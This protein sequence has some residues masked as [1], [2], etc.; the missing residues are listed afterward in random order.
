MWDSQLFNDKIF[1]NP[2]KKRRYFLIPY[3]FH[4]THHGDYFIILIRIYFSTF[5]FF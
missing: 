3:D 5:R 4:Q 2:Y 1:Y